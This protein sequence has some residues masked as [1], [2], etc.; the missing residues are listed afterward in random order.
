MRTTTS[1]SAR[2]V[3]LI[4]CTTLAATILTVPATPLASAQTAGLLDASAIAPHAASYGYYVDV[5]DTNVSSDLN[6]SSNAAVGVLDEMLTLWTPGAEWNTGT[7]VDAT[8]LDSNIAQSV[9]ISEQAT[10]AEQQR[11]YVIDRRNQNY[12]ATDGLGAYAER[13][14]ETAQIGTT[15]PDEVPADAST[16]KYDDGGNANGNWAESGGELGSTVDLIGAIR[17]HSATSN[18]AKAFYQYPR[19]YRWTDSIEPEVWGDG[20]DMPDYAYPLRKDES[21]ASTDGGFPSG[22]TSAGG[23]AT[24]GLAYAFPQQYDELLMTAAEIGTSRIQ[25]GMH[26]PLDVIGGRILSTAITAGALS[27]PALDAVKEQAFDDAQLWISDQS[28]ITANDRDFDAQLAEYTDFLTFGFEQT[29]DT[30]EEMRVPKGAEALL[31]TRLPYLNDEQRRWVLHSTGLESGFPPLD[32]EEGWGRLNL[33]A[34]QAGYS[35]F[36][37]NVGV[38]MN[39]EDGGFSAADNWQNDIEGAG[40]LTKN[41]SGELTLSGDNSYTGGTTITGGT[42][43]AATADALGTGDLTVSDQATLKLEQPVTIEGAAVLDGALHVSLP[44]GS[45]FTAGVTVLKAGNI[46]GE[47]DEIIVDGSSNVTASYVN[48]AVVLTTATDGSNEDTTGSSTGSSAGSILAILASLGGIAALIL[49]A[50]NQFGLPPVVKN[51]LNI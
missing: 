40:S 31:E 35:A 23:M 29:G 37:T 12:T 42:L 48:G 41:G 16:V 38:T 18:N 14:R 47:F 51:F 3:G 27:D 34:A 13:Y 10:D 6:P 19:P 46:S 28:D 50:I 22:H 39:A 25:L 15:I 32:D 7:K 5:W 21:V 43:V 24:N 1:T 45:D 33:Y 20:V 49:G 2:P 30:T 9:T 11:A 8:V 44:A 26:S 17:N 36:D 4:L